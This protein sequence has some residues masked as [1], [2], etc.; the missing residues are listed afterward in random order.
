[1]EIFFPPFRLLAYILIII[2]IIISSSIIIVVVVVV[3]LHA[4]EARLLSVRRRDKFVF[5]CNDSSKLEAR[6]ALPLS[7]V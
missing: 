5:P 7:T 1:M 6:S 3:A 4:S 2:L